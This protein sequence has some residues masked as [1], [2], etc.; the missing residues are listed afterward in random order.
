[1]AIDLISEA[2]ALF[3]IESDSVDFV[4]DNHLI[5]HLTNPIKA[6]LEWERV[7]KRNGILYLAFPNILSNEYDFKRN[8]TSLGH[9]IEDYKD[10]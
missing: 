1:M 4:I 7:L 5:E 10:V 2:D 9:I 8:P 3:N 6:I